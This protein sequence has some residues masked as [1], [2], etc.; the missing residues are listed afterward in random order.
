[1][2]QV[3]SITCDA[4]VAPGSTALASYGG[5]G[6]GYRTF[7]NHCHYD[8]TGEVIDTYPGKSFDDCINTCAFTYDCVAASWTPSSC[9]TRSTIGELVP[10][11]EVWSFTVGKPRTCPDDNGSD[12]RGMTIECGIDYPGGD[13][14][15]SQTA[16]LPGCINDCLATDQC[17]AVTY[18]GTACYKKSKV[19]VPVPHAGQYSA[20]MATV[21]PAQPDTPTQQPDAPAGPSCPNDD[22]K[23]YNGYT[24][25]C[26]IDYPGV[27][28]F[29]FTTS[30]TFGGCIDACKDHIGCVAV[31]YSGNACY[32]KNQV[33]VPVDHPGLATAKL[34]NEVP[35]T[36]Q[37]DPQVSGRSCPRDDTKTVDGYEIQCDKDYLGG[38]LRAVHDVTFEGCISECEADSSC[39]DV[40]WNHGSCY[41][42]NK[43]TT[44]LPVPLGGVWNARRVVVRGQPADPTP[45]VVDNSPSCPASNGKKIIVDEI[46]FTVQCGADYVGGDFSAVHGVTFQQCLQAC[47]NTGKCLDLA[48]NHGSCYLKS[49][50]T[51]A[52]TNDAVWGAIRYVEK[53][54]EPPVEDPGY[55]TVPTPE[56]DPG[57]DTPQPPEPQ[58]LP[59]EDEE[60]YE[61]VKRYQ[62]D[63][64]FKRW[65]A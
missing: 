6:P 29:G 24:V 31:A 34:P 59:E 46:A 40:A 15:S 19:G 7:D 60:Y 42:K 38:D 1:M 17:V 13:I 27:G 53:E 41:L 52:V 57:Y 51:T 16:D 37:P 65:K 12:Y 4:S 28:D 48:F 36:S 20:R 10:S 2:G 5:L 44:S 61:R 55:E 33:G 39:I 43:L 26:G 22:G 63:G 56:E 25:G 54:E 58:P 62:G 21:Q 23:S 11:N 14:G 47:A 8:T 18:S 35:Q 3:H 64:G 30:D 49:T 45:P 50:V 9:K 32:M